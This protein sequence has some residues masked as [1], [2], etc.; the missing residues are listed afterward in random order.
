MTVELRGK[1]ALVTGA[2]G[3][4]GGHLAFAL[5]D[6]GCRVRALVRDPG[7]AERLAAAGIEIARGDLQDGASL[8][9]AVRGC[10]WVFH[11]AA[12]LGH[13]SS[14]WAQF[15]RVNVE[16]TRLLA[17][18]A[19]EAGVERFVQASSIWA[20]GLRAGRDTDERTP[21]LV[22]GSP[23]ADT[24]LESEQ[25]VLALA[26]AGRLAAVV[27]QPGIVYGPRDEAFTLA[28]LKLMRAGLMILPGCGR[29]LAN[30]IYIDD[31]I[32]G[33]LTVAR[34][35]AVGESYILTSGEVVT[36][37]EFFGRLGRMLGRERIPSLPRWLS[38][39]VARLTEWQARLA[40]TRPL[41]TVEAVRGTTMQATYRN[42]KARALG[43]TPQVTLDEGMR[44]VE[45]WLRTEGQDY[46]KRR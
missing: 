33:I 26:R 25:A 11:F 31:L 42:E 39:A 29:G 20:Y 35:G 41:L 21:R 15:R 23:Y 16:G 3:F 43:F 45:A 27:V 14:S 12:V 8:A 38:L 6:A 19:A 17:E 28:P 9:S 7:K 34:E 36:F 32:A 30:P 18:A 44:R 1:T 46:L 4:I 40:G 22:S 5:R 13:E 2:T 37:R 24:K 10:R